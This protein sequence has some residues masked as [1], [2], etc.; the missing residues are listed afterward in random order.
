VVSRDL[1]LLLLGAVALERGAEL[2]LSRRNAA[3]AFARGGLEVGQ[4]HF[5]VMSL[6]HALFL[7]ACAAEVLLLDRPFPGATGLA[8]LA[9]VVLAQSLRWWAVAT[10]G[11]R[12]NVRIVVVPGEAPVTRGPYRFVRHPNYLAVIVE[13]LCLPL[14]HGA[15]LTA[16][17]FSLANA[18][19]LVV[20]I[21]A[22]EAA[23]GE[24]YSAAFAR[25]PRFVP[26]ARP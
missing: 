5:R 25:T 12:W 6:V 17:V 24:G 11:D 2:V 7:V 4:A 9:A 13:L 3:R 14:V 19:L 21:R 22:E 15:V 1:Y 10:L 16:V 23:L 26:G 20:R 18:A 8:A